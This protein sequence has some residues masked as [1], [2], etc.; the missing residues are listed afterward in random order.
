LIRKCPG[1][2]GEHP[3][4]RPKE[5]ES[6]LT[7]TTIA[8]PGQEPQTRI[9]KHKAVEQDDLRILYPVEEELLSAVEHT[10]A[11]FEQWDRHADHSSDFGGEQECIKRLR[12]ALREAYPRDEL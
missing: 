5:D 11:W 9:E 4:A 10:L 2:V 6:P 1:G 12:F 3:E 8:Q 7:K